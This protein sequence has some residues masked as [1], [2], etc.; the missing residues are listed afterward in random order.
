MKGT[1]AQELLQL[2][3]AG[4]G[5]TAVGLEGQLQGAH[6]TAPE[7]AEH[8]GTQ[9][10]GPQPHAGWKREGRLSGGRANSPPAEGKGEAEHSG[11]RPEGL[12]LSAQPEL[13][14]VMDAGPESSSRPKGLVTW[15]MG[16]SGGGRMDSVSSE[17]RRMT[18]TSKPHLQGQTVAP[19]LLHRC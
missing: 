8:A 1:R 11:W 15:T 4:P 19:S 2:L 13:L 12:E 18:G 10:H 3:P 14:P 5:A 9:T 17:L 16:F 7:A 6:L